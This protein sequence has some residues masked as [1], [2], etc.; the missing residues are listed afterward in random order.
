MARLSAVSNF[1]GI[2]RGLR[3]WG[4]TKV[5]SECVNRYCY[6]VAETKKKKAI[7]HQILVKNGLKPLIFS[8]FLVQKCAIRMPEIVEISRFIFFTVHP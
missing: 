7:S 8:Y 5:Q 3:R 2:S 6:K 4:A 1:V